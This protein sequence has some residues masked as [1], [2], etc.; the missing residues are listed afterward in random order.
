MPDSDFTVQHGYQEL[1]RQGTPPI[2]LRNQDD[3]RGKWDAVQ[4]PCSGKASDLRVWMKK[5]ISSQVIHASCFEDHSRFDFEKLSWAWRSILQW[6]LKP[7]LNAIWHLSRRSGGE[8]IDSLCISWN[9]YAATCFAP[10]GYATWWGCEKQLHRK[11][12][13]Y[14]KNL[15][16]LDL[17]CLHYTLIPAYMHIDI[18]IDYYSL[19]SRDSSLLG[20]SRVP[21][22]EHG[23]CVS[24]LK[25][26]VPKTAISAS[27]Q[28]KLLPNH[29]ESFR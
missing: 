25:T 12:W 23:G 8:S 24:K 10:L 3:H 29:D 1:W 28:S 19:T 18:Y 4:S 21:V 9:S 11:K 17:V 27:Y 6:F 16:Q 20:Y 15:S 13:N 5:I 22:N 7:F 2:H 26:E 14:W